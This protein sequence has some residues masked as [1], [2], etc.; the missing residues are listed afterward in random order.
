MSL[1]PAETTPRSCLRDLKTEV[2]IG[3]KVKVNIKMPTKLI[4]RRGR[5]DLEDG[6]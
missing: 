3:R 4:P 5:K 6:S 2:Q 1:S